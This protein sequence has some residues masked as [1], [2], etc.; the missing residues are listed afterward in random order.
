MINSYSKT[1]SGFIFIYFLL[2][3]ETRVIVHKVKKTQTERSENINKYSDSM[4][5]V[6]LKHWSEIFLIEAL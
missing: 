4:I 5:G 2:V 6:L 3:I 1:Y